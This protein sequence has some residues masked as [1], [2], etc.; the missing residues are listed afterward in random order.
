[1]VR[2]LS[3][4]LGLPQDERAARPASVPERGG[5]VP[6][7]AEEASSFPM[8]ALPWPATPSWAASTN[9][10]RLAACSRGCSRGWGALRR[11][12]SPWGSR[13]RLRGASRAVRHSS[14]SPPWAISRSLELS[15]GRARIP[16]EALI[17]QLR[18]KSLLLVLDNLEHLLQAAPKVA[19]L[20]EA[21]PGLVV[22]STSRAP[23]RVRGE[24]E[25]PVPP[26]ALPASTRS[27]SEEQVLASPSGMHFVER[28]RAPRRPPSRAGLEGRGALSHTFARR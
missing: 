21:C 5:S 10:R 3:D 11:P 19:A 23:L 26:L 22:M 20:V 4:A 17:G 1:M 7:D 18:E 13:K 27:P 2:S 24:R 9:S 15:E 16:G 6:S 25:Y 14:D 8:A 28:V 12:A